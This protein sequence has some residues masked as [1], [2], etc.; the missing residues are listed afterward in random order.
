MFYPKLK[1][2]NSVYSSPVR[3]ENFV[4]LACIKHT[5]SVHPEP[6]S[7]SYYTNLKYLYK[8]KLI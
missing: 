5:T 4:Q 8:I 1:G 7:N 6:G 2:K 3:Y